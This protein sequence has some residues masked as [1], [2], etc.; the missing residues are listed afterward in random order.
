MHPRHPARPLSTSL[1]TALISCLALTGLLAFGPCTLP[2]P[3]DGGEFSLPDLLDD[4]EVYTDRDGVRHIVAQN[5]HDLAYVQGWIHARDRFFEMD[6][7]RREVSGDL[8]ELIGI[9]ALGSDIQNR[10]VGLRR[11]SERSEGALGPEELSFLQAYADGINQWLA[12]EPLPP[13]YTE[14]ELTS[15]REWNV[16]DTLSVG[17]AI[18]ASLSLDI[19]SSGAQKLSEYVEAGIAGGYDGAALLTEDVQRF[20]PM[21]PAS[22]VPDADGTMPFL[23]RTE[24]LDR[25]FL[26][27]AAE[28]GREVT[29]KFQASRMLRRAMNWR[30]TQMGS[31]EWG[32]AGEHTVDG[33]PLIANDPHLS[34]NQPSTF[35]EVHLAVVDDPTNGPLNASGVGFPGAPGVILGQN[36]NVTWGATT[37]PMDVTDLFLDTIESRTPGCIAAFPVPPAGDGT[38]LCIVSEGQYHKM[39]FMLTEYF[40]NRVGD[41]IQDNVTKEPLDVGSSVIATVPF[42]SFGPMVFVDDVNVILGTGTT[43]GLFLQFTGFH[44]TRE[45]QTFLKWNRASNIAEFLDGVHDFDFG[46]QNW[47]YA[48]KDGNLAY[49]SS[50]ELPLRKDLE[51]G[52]VVGN[53]PFMI[54]DGS[55]PN[56]WVADP[57]RSQGQSI[58]YAILPYDEMPQLLNPANDWHQRE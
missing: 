28:A 16:V 46:S 22:T 47:V 51:D 55:G 57:A 14:L 2:P 37:N 10:T 43:T 52:A 35:Y 23:A 17:K 15:A 8:A 27:K 45:V 30:E 40:V 50:A 25:T 20:A 29:Q 31:N 33:R 32:V 34:L 26:A 53:P 36:E 5:D 11:A 48:D 4:V 56:N 54:R 7:T 58:P 44:A 18:A 39:D 42:R 12:T 19:D 1:S 9:Q 3:K 6:A 21:D 38:G 24:N 49:F 41:S 13:E